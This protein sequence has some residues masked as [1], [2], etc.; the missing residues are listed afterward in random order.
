MK[1][2]MLLLLLCTVL[3]ASDISFSAAAGAHL[4]AASA[5]F[6]QSEAMYSRGCP[7][8][9]L[10]YGTH[11]SP[12]RLGGEMAAFTLG[13]EAIDYLLKRHHKR[14]WFVPGAVMTV[15]HARAAS[16]DA[17]LGTGFCSA[18]KTDKVSKLSKTP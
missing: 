5:D 6:I 2:V 17:T 10:L 3:Q 1:P 13:V 16:R 15:L 8:T 18:F 9:D 12:G 14:I 11:P 7:E 4:A